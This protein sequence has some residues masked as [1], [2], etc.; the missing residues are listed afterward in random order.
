ML[1]T[2]PMQQ[3]MPNRPASTPALIAMGANATTPTRMREFVAFSGCKTPV[4]ALIKR[5]GMRVHA[6]S[7]K[8]P[9]TSLK[10][11]LVKCARGTSPDSFSEGFPRTLRLKPVIRVRDNLQKAIHDEPCERE[12]PRDIHRRKSR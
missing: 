4:C 6:T 9:T 3:A 1:S 8:G 5:Y 2:G 7:T 12:L 11:M 10:K